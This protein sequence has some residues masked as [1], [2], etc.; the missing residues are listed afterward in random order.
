LAEGIDSRAVF[1]VGN[2]M[3]DSLQLFW[4]RAASSTILA[5]LNRSR[6]K[7]LAEIVPGKFALATLHRAGNVDDPATLTT[8]LSALIRIAEDLAVVFPMH[9]RTRKL[10]ANL[11]GSFVKRLSESGVLI[12]DPLG[13]LDFLH[14]QT[15]AKLVLTDS[16]GVQVETSYLGIPCLTLRD[17]TEWQVTLRN[18][19]NRL[20]RASEVEIVEAAQTVIAQPKPQPARIPNWD[21]QT[22]RRIIEVFSECFNA[23]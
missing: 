5:K 11:D 15:Q 6:P 17:R 1:R 3:V 22:S 9:P 14:L 2:I 4:D 23:T 21:G 7:Q 10:L 20:V 16:G 8:I 13:Y 12:S 18:G 19:T